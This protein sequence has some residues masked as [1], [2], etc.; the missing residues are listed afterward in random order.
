[1]RDPYTS[2]EMTDDQQL[3]PFDAEPSGELARLLDDATRTRRLELRD[4]PLSAE[5]VRA[6]AAS[7][8]L[9]EVR[10]LRL[11]ACGV[12]EAGALALA[13]SPNVAQLE[14]LE[15]A[16]HP[17]RP[18][19]DAGV[20]ALSGSPHLAGLTALGLY[21]DD[22]SDDAVEAIV[23][24]D[25]ELE[26]LDLA[27]NRLTARGARAL[28]GWPALRGI[29]TL[30]LASNPLGDDG[31][32]ALCESPHLGALRELDL[33]AVEMGDAGA[34]ALARSP[35]LAHLERLGLDEN[36]I[37]DDGA[38]ALA[39]SAHLGALRELR[40]GNNPI[41]EPGLDALTRALAD[42]VELDLENLPF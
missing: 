10:D 34:H 36:E 2:R 17:S 28:A 37:G 27:D 40:I 30:R 41:G 16:Y 29:N 24:S 9:A 5:T 1:M 21:L 26:A 33:G 18:V 22:L 23:D 31:V 13:A 8:A 35:K 12:G 14:R 19:G 42:R 39:E 3:S 7:P 25:W 20:R 6:L 32:A 11:W 38:R 4:H 15:L